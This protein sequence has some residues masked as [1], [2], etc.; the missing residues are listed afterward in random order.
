MALYETVAG[1]PRSPAKVMSGG[2]RQK[3]IC[4]F[5]SQET[6]PAFPWCEDFARDK[7]I[8]TLDKM[9]ITLLELV[10]IR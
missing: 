6:M 7:P 4:I 5:R 1:K 8:C 2:R 10:Y 9:Q 3:D